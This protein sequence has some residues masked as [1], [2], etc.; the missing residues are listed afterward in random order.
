MLATLEL[1]LLMVVSCHVSV[2]NHHSS[3]NISFL[4]K[5]TSSSFRMVSLHCIVPK[6]SVVPLTVKNA[7]FLPPVPV[8]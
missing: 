5:M 2:G 7:S 4:N 3:P 1:E 6:V 8:S